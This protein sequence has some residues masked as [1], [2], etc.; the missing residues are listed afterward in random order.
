MLLSALLGRISALHNPA[1]SKPYRKTISNPNIIS[2][3]QDN[4]D[5]L[6]KTFI[7]YIVLIKGSDR[8]RIINFSIRGNKFAEMKTFGV[9]ITDAR[10]WKS[11]QTVCLKPCPSALHVLIAR[12]PAP[13]ARAG[14]ALRQ[15]TDL[16]NV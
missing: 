4:A 5:L 3:W 6:G 11:R 13:G 10:Q 12:Y 8:N 9:L 15:R 14:S 1:I 16:N 7:P 2:S